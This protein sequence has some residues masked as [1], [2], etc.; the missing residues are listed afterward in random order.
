MRF[1]LVLVILASA[2]VAAEPVVVR[3]VRYGDTPGDATSAH[4]LDVY[5]PADPGAGP[6]PVMVYV[7]GGGWKGGDKARVGS[8][9]EYFTGRGWAFASVNYRLLPAGIRPTSTTWRPRSR[10]CT[11]MPPSTASTRT[12]SS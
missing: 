10:G 12:R 7:H 3:D 8:K 9:A 2:S 5:T 1:L 4:A 11:T 6:T